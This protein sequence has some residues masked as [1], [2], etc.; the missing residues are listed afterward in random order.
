MS[1]LFVCF[2][3]C[4]CFNYLVSY[5]MNFL[6]FY[7]RTKRISKLKNILDNMDST[8]SKALYASS[9]EPLRRVK[10]CLPTFSDQDLKMKGTVP[11]LYCSI[12]AKQGS[13]LGVKLRDLQEPIY[14]EDESDIIGWQ[15]HSVEYNHKGYQT[16]LWHA[17]C[18]NTSQCSCDAV[19]EK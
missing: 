1:N 6:E 17:C 14:D 16:S 10:L 11:F 13:F 3:C 7:N 19:M 18:S 5:L 12:S 4:R 2:C 9:K 8:M 15:T